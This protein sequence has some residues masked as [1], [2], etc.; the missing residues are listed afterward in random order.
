MS[1]FA[2]VDT[3]A[4]LA[5]LLREPGAEEVHGAED[6]V[7]G[8]GLEDGTQVVGVPRDPVHLD[9]ELHG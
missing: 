3:S 4:L 7:P 6:E 5:I 1:G 9:A 8:V 2:Y